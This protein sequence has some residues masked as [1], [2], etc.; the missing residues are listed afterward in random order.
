MRNGGIRTIRTCLLLLFLVLSGPTPGFAQED[1]TG[2]NP[3]NFTY[4]ARFY[5][6]MAKLD[7]GGA[8]ITNTFELR[9]PLGRNVANIRGDQSDS[10][11]NRMGQFA[12]LRFRGRHAGLSVPA[13]GSGAFGTA[14]VSG[15]GDFDVRLL[16]LAYTSPNLI[17]A[18]GVEAFFDTASNEALGAGQASL[19]PQ[20][21][22]VFP[23]VL[24][25]ASLFAP[26]YQYVFDVSG[27]DDLA[28]I[29]RSQIDLY[30]VW[31]LA[32][33]RNWL[34][35]DPQIILDHDSGKEL[36]TIETELG[37]VIAPS[38]GA[39]TYVRPGWGVTEEK[40]YAWNLEV[41]LK[42]VWR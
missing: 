30:F 22:A 39:S 11:F 14:E 36:A 28:D 38:A 21:F 37:F 2:T 9:W 17:I 10:V 16:T 26:G 35:V 24:G 12:S 41:G 19:G 15:I 6:E 32:G 31:M 33:G 1:N 13:P 7:G 4:D 42:F 25:G 20:V 27:D 18:A 23:G 40:L 3:V 34:I 29:R 5:T 8:L